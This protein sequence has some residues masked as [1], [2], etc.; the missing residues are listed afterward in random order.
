MFI[1]LPKFGEDFL[2][3]ALR[4]GKHNKNYIDYYIGP[5]KLSEIVG[6]EDIISPN[7]LLR[8]CE[9]L[10][11]QLFNQGFDKGREKYLEKMLISM[12]TSLEILNG[13]KLP[14]KD[15]F[16][17]LYDAKLEPVKQSELDALIEDIINVYGGNEGFEAK[18]LKLRKRRMVPPGDVYELFEKAIN[19][20]RDRTRD[21]FVGIF[22]NEEEIIIKLVESR[23]D[24]A[25]W[26]YYQQYQGNFR[27]LIE[28]NPHFGIYSTSLLFYAA[29]EGYPGH[30]TEFTIKEQKLYNDLNQ[31]EHLILLLNSPKLL[32]S[33]GI[34]NH[35][36]NMLYTFSEEARIT[37]ENFCISGSKGDSPETLTQENKVRGRVQLFWYDLAYKALVENWSEEKLMSYATS[38]KIYTKNTIK[39]RLI[40]LK[41]PVHSS[42][43]F[44][45]EL[46]RNLIINKYGEFPSIKNFRNLLETSVLPSDM[47]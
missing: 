9:I 28:V 3:L 11:K 41:D 45:Y 32:V 14:F 10:R 8:D 4:I 24:M 19:I 2:L 5:K 29:H 12:K 34:A 30:H 40:S 46:G 25:K 33:E 27:S 18:M 15:Q 26:S 13:I 36:I 31:F 38:F 1:K 16:F 35:A 42:T 39:N 47:L 17:R 20:V 37:A 21:L 6:N 22:Q 23:E 43:I 44:S 7:K